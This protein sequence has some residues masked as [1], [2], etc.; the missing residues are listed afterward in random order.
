MVSVPRVK[1]LLILIL[2]V[3]APL[4]IYHSRRVPEPGSDVRVT[5]VPEDVKKVLGTTPI[6]N[7]INV[8]IPI[9]LYH[10]VEY[11]Q[12]KK[13]T[14]RQ[15]LNIP[16]YVF[17]SQIETL[18]NAG[19]N[20]V[21]TSDVAKAING[22]S[23]LPQ[24]PVVLTFD[25]GYMD[26][27]TDVF[28]ILKKENVRAEEYIISDFLNRPNFMFTFQVKDIARSGLVEI[29][30]HT[31]DH[32]WLKGMPKKR[33]ELQIFQSR[34]VIE[35]ITGRPVLSFAYPYGAFDQQTIELTREAG[36]TNAV[37]T[38]PGIEDNKN[39]EYYMYRIRPGYRTGKELLNYLKQNIFKAY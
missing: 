7:N 39:N 1:L 34:E 17:A 31:E 12:D 28:P 37:S 29:G 15:S 6:E 27:Y 32:V 14:I 10:Y 11:V 25:D 35:K 30:A 21:T 2:I 36:Y 26:F 5:K 24:N 8:R 19:Y 9:L 22:G 13:D 33:A 20:F 4:L 18:K 38:I 23:K 3:A 16:P